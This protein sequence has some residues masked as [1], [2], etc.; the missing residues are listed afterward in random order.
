MPTVRNALEKGKAPERGHDRFGNSRGIGLINLGI[1]RRI[2]QQGT[3]PA[4]EAADFKHVL[5]GRRGD[6]T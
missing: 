2:T 6:G 1:L 3:K 4:K 5:L